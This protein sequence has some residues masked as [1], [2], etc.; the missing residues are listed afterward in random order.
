MSERP[1]LNDAALDDALALVIGC[2][3]GIWHRRMRAF[4]LTP[5]QAITLRKLLDGPLPM[6]SV[7][8]VLSCDASTL[9]GIADRLEERRLIQRQLDPADRRVKLLALT[10]AGRELVESIDGPFTAEIPGLAALSEQERV[11]LTGLLLRAFG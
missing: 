3:R 8:E 9:T 7:A 11:E 6:G 2:M 4:D 5:P 10:E 1:E